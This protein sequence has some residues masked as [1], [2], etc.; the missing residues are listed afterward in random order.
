MVLVGRVSH[1][2]HECPL[3]VP[4]GLSSAST[5]RLVSVGRRPRRVAAGGGNSRGMTAGRVGRHPGS[6]WQKARNVL[7]S[8]DDA[9]YCD[10]AGGRMIERRTARTTEK[11]KLVVSTWVGS[12]SCHTPGFMAM[13]CLI[14]QSLPTWGLGPECTARDARHLGR[15][16]ITTTTR[17]GSRSTRA[18]HGPGLP[19]PGGDRPSAMCRDPA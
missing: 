15:L 3:R 1:G 14:S 4:A 19:G 10:G 7:N 11:K 2:E 6:L 8:V 13:D 17:G 9:G 16:T 18:L 12:E 5:A